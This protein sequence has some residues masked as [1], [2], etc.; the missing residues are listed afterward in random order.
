[1][2][3]FKPYAAKVPLKRRTKGKIGIPKSKQPTHASPNKLAEEL[4]RWLENKEV[5]RD[6]R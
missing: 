3:K 4:R 5:S 6:G 2:A 1:M